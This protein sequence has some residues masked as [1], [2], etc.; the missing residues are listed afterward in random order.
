VAAGARAVLDGLTLA[1]GT[2]G[3]NAGCVLVAA[4]GTITIR[5]SIMTNCIADNNGGALYLA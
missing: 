3:A 1:N 5:N 4:G 2:S